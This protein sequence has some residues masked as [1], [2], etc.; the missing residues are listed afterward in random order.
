MMEQYK[1]QRSS[2]S[3]TRFRH[4]LVRRSVQSGTFQTCEICIR[5]FDVTDLKAI[6]IL[7]SKIGPMDPIERNSTANGLLLC[8]ICHH[9]KDELIVD[10]S[11]QSE[12]SKII[13]LRNPYYK[14]PGFLQ[15]LGQPGWPTEEIIRTAADYLVQK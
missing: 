4:S 15:H 11:L 7:P 8:P 14:E 5:S 9:M 12:S 1:K 13:L 6:H 2:M 10:I 3:K